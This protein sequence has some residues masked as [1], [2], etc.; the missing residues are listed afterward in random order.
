MPVS[1]RTADFRRTRRCLSS[2]LL[3][4]RSSS[5]AGGGLVEQ[6]SIHRVAIVGPGLDFTDKSD[7][8]DFYPI[9]TI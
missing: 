5:A 7:G 1:I 4:A 8:F 9:Q 3:I 2:F 6:S